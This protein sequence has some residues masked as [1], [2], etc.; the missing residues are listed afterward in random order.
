[1]N[2]DKKRFEYDMK[3]GKEVAD[4]KKDKYIPF[5]AVSAIVG[6]EYPYK[7]SLASDYY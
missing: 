2:F 3:D 5:D 7:M 6:R 1:V 4:L